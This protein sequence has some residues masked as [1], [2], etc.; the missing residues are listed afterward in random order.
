VTPPRAR[1]IAIDGP[2]AS[3]KSTT[4]AAVAG[5]LGWMHLDSGA[6][7]RALTWVAVERHLEDPAA[8]K[9]AAEAL[10]VR[11]VRHGS[12]LDVHLDGVDDVEAAIRSAA[13]NARVPSLAALP[14]LRA[15]VNARQ[16]G[17]IAEFGAL[18]I[19]GRDIGTVVAPDAP[20]KIFLTAT[21]AER[22]RR[23]LLQR[24]GAV[25]P[26]LLAAE[27]A[28]L[29]ERDRIDGARAAAPLRQAGDAVAL[30]TTGM[31]F[32]AQVRR[33]VAL[34]GERGLAAG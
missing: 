18:V 29:E 9:A 14:A 30:D 11:L 4:A 34:A 1:V 24:D 10:H 3:G 31:T 28:R 21:A 5:A 13:V 22:A 15:W 27:T 7:Y 25:D 32:D 17:A 6:L 26:L 12:H 8:I 19:D 20:L 2:A 23:R 33:I 16:R